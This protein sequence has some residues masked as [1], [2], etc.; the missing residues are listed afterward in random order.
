MQNLTILASAMPEISFEATKLKVG[1]VTLTMTLLRVIF[2]PYA[3]TILYF[4]YGI[5]DC[6]QSSDSDEISSLFSL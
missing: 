2:H 1:H 5:H 3:G 6:S 4:K